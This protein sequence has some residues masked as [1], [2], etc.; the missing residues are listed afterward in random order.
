MRSQS[1]SYHGY[2]FPPDII[3]HAVWLYHR[4]CLRRPQ[5]SWTRIKGESDVKGGGGMVGSRRVKGA[6]SARTEGARRASGVGADGAAAWPSRW[7]DTFMVLLVVSWRAQIPAGRE[8][9]SP[10]EVT[11]ASHSP[12]STG[13]GRSPVLSGG[14]NAGRSATLADP[15]R[16]ETRG[17]GVEPSVSLPSR[18]RS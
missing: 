7:P 11:S 18:S 14:T 8:L 3:S 6:V 16:P 12:R 1:A 5:F 10:S 13:I 15:V 9:P 17:S 2:R 4:F